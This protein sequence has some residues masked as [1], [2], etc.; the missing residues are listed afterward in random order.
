MSDFL[1]FSISLSLFQLMYAQIEG[2]LCK[3]STCDLTT[4]NHFFFLLFSLQS[5]SWSSLKWMIGEAFPFLLPVKSVKEAKE[6]TPLTYDPEWLGVQKVACS[7][8][9]YATCF[10]ILLWKTT[11]FKRVDEPLTWVTDYSKLLLRQSM[12]CT[13]HA[14][15]RMPCSRCTC[16]PNEKPLTL[17]REDSCLSVN[18]NEPF[19]PL[20]CTHYAFTIMIHD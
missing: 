13:P 1:S 17:G 20:W 5:Q 16:Q 7:Y 4:L 18:E 6:R 15:S 9:S 10:P 14:A 3:R 19:S 12:A 2:V 8:T 11:S